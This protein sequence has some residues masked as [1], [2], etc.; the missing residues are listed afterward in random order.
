MH[1]FRCVLISVVGVFAA[2]Q[3]RHEWRFWGGDAGGTRYSDLRQ[4]RAENV[5]TLARAWSYHTGETA[6]PGP[7][8][9]VRRDVAFEATPLEIDGVLYFTTAGSRAIALD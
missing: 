3:P 4:I 9:P 7:V 5:A 1:A 2:A 6:A 8:S